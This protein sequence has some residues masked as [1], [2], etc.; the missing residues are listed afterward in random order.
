MMFL[1]KYPMKFILYQKASMLMDS[2]TLSSMSEH[3]KPSV[4]E[5]RNYSMAI[6]Y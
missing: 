4:T 2:N 3:A 1:I 6:A 5:K